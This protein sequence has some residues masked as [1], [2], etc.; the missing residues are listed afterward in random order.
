MDTYNSHISK[1]N[2]KNIL[3]KKCNKAYKCD[4]KRI[5]HR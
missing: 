3:S 1:L 4:R 2:L 5:E